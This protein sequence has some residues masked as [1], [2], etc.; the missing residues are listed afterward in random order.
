MM[1][2]MKRYPSITLEPGKRVSNRILSVNNTQ[3]NEDKFY[4]I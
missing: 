1:I 3:T 4:E 2:T